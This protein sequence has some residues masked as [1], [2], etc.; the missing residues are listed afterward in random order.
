MIA[1]R[2]LLLVGYGGLIAG[3]VP[4]LRATAAVARD[5]TT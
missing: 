4:L 3:A 1:L 2:L 5:W